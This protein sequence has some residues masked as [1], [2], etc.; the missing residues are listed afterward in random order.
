MGKYYEEKLCEISN[1]I[2]KNNENVT[3]K[4][5]TKTQTMT[6]E[7]SKTKTTIIHQRKRKK[8]CDQKLAEKNSK[9]L[10]SGK[11]DFDPEE[12]LD[13]SLLFDLRK[14]TSEDK[15]FNSIL[16]KFPDKNDIYYIKSRERTN[17][18]TLRKD[19]KKAEKD[20]LIT[21]LE[22]VD[23]AIKRSTSKSKLSWLKQIKK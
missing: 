13:K 20:E 7:S 2:Y 12:I 9:L 19:P 6:V 15:V 1:V 17:A 23:K 21:M 11:F 16:E 10:S 22:T 5:P 8:L 14:K 4:K 3:R 18:F